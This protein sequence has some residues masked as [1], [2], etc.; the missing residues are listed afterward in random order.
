MAAKEQQNEKAKENDK[1]LEFTLRSGKK[2]TLDLSLNTGN[3]LIKCRDLSGGS[4]T[5]IYLISEIGLFDGEKIPA[6]EIL[7]WSAFDI[8]EL[9]SIWGNLSKQK[10]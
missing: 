4:A 8:I 3:L 9:E 7:N 1:I 6:P 5:V 2:L 10:K